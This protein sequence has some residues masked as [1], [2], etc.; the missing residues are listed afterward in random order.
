MPNHVQTAW[1]LTPAVLGVLG[2]GPV[3]PRSVGCARST[4]AAMLSGMIAWK[5]PPKNA[6]ARIE[7]GDHRRQVAEIMELQTL[8]S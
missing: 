1:P 6:H 8:N 4:I 3:Q 7:P 2:E 5:T